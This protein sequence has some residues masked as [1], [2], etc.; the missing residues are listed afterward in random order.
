M[1]T[2]LTAQEEQQ[3]LAAIDNYA[4]QKALVPGDAKDLF[5]EHWDTVKEV[6][7]FLQDVL[8]P[9]ISTVIKYV[10]KF[11]DIAHS[12]ICKAQG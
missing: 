9:P 5:C 10:I 12:K 2:N 8:P 4:G 11:G 1:D 6:L 7:G 3:I